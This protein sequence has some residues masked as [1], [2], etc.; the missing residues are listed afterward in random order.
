MAR[1]STRFNTMALLLAC[2]L[3]GLAGGVY[4]DFLAGLLRN[5]VAGYFPVLRQ[6]IVQALKAAEPEISCAVVGLVVFGLGA[7]LLATLSLTGFAQSLLNALL[8]RLRDK[9]LLPYSFEANKK[10]SGAWNI[11]EGIFE[12]IDS[13]VDQLYGASQDSKRFQDALNTYADPT[14]A[15]HLRSGHGSSQ[16]I[17]TER[18][19]VAVLFADIRGFTT[20]SEVLLPEQVAL[21]LDDYFTFATAAITK[22]GGSV[23]KFIGDAVMALFEQKARLENYNPT[24]SAAVAA[25]TMVS[26]FDRFLTVWTSRVPQHFDAGLGVGI[27]YGEAILGTLGSPERKE[28]TAIGDTVNFASRLCSLAKHGEIRISEDGF[29]RI[30]EY[31]DGTAQEAVQ[32]KGKAGTH[33][34]Y[35]LGRQKLQ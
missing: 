8:K 31:F 12:L 23:N 4:F 6:D 35:L 11:Q 1:A 24:K 21:I 7:Y 2:A 18:R 9:K 3:L 25:R 30:Q 17:R 27:H 16:F 5:F 33:V 22:E 29:E 13:Y 15:E 28:Y 32:V 14:V 10:R 26:E 19:P 20:M 34:T